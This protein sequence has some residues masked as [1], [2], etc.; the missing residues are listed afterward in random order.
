ME[1]VEM[2]KGA[3]YH[4]EAERIERESSVA[5]PLTRAQL[6]DTGTDLDFMREDIQTSFVK[7][8][9]ISSGKVR[10]YLFGRADKVVR[11]QQTLII[12]D[13][14]HTSNLG[15]YGSMSEPYFS[16]M[17]QVLAY[18]NSRYYLGE[19]FGGWSEIPH[20]YKK[21]QI[22]IVDSRDKSVYKRF[23]GVVTGVHEELFLDAAASFALKCLSLER[24]SHHNSEKKCKA[25]G[26]FGDCSN[27]LK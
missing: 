6:E 22:N 19:S 17:L 9:D 18:L 12:S 21:Y 3:E 5:V 7:E 16:Q 27:A 20:V 4:E 14:K 8:F 23:E 26:Y 1:T 10:L 25:C 13:D 11:R 24:L 15:R 2:S